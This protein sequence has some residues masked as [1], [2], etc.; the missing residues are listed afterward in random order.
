[1][2]TRNR[3]TPIYTRALRTFPTL[4]AAAR[5]VNLLAKRDGLS[6]FAIQ[7]L[8]ADR[9]QVSRVMGGVA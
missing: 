1:M 4:A 7:Q 5:H 9:W 8:A 6:R 3:I 2:Q